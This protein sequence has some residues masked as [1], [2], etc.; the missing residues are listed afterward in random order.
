MGLYKRKGSKFYWMT[1]TENGRRRFV[2]TKTTNKR[3]AEKI[4]ARIV[5]DANEGKLL[6]VGSVRRTLKDMIEKYDTEYTSQKKYQSRDRSIFKHLKEFFGEDTLLKDIEMSIIDY[7]KFRTSSGASP[8]TVVK[9][10]G[11]L[12]RMFNI[13]IKRWKWVRDNP[14]NLIEMPKVKNERVRYL[15]SDERNRLLNALENEHLPGWLKPIV[16]IALNT[17]LRQSNLLNLRWSQV[18]LFA[19]RIVIEGTEMKNRENIAIPLTKEAVETFSKLQ[20]IKNNEDYVFHDNG[21]RIYPVKLQRAFRRACMIAE[22]ENFRFHDLRH[23]FASCLR[24]GGIDIHTISK[25]LGHKDI[26]MTQRYAHLSVENL[27]DA[28]SVLEKENGYNSVTVEEAR[29]TEC[30]VTP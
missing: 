10:L 17:G 8:A 28:I 24:Q 15:S 19:R 3:H 6:P 1:F 9:E 25:L 27:R 11:L 16:I 18:D 12:R 20:K 21:R 22:I 23:T 7:E 26:R 30:V 14:V 5:T 29:G 2:S 4:Y 13:A